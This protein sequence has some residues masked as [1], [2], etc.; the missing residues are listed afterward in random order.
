MWWV[1]VGGAA[2]G[3]QPQFYWAFITFRDLIQASYV[4]FTYCSTV[5]SL[6][7]SGGCLGVPSSCC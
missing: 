2:F 3:P 7:P 1:N 6:R 5:D 4:G